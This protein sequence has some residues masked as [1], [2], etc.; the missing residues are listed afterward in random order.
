M[1]LKSAEMLAIEMLA[2]VALETLHLKI[3]V[4]M[5]VGGPRISEVTCGGS[6]HLSSKEIQL[7]M[8]DRSNDIVTLTIANTC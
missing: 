4:Y 2:I 5:D 7:K 8:R 6:T 3:S 1:H